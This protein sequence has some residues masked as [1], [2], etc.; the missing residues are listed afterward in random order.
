MFSCGFTTEDREQCRVHRRAETKKVKDGF[1]M[2]DKNDADWV[3]DCMR[4]K[5]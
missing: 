2:P 1:K 5:V 3:K 4:M